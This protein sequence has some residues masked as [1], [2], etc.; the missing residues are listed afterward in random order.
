LPDPL[1]S[2]PYGTVLNDSEGQLIGAKISSDGQWRFP[3]ID[4]VPIYFEEAIT[5]F[6]DKRFRSHIGVDFLSVGRAAIQNLKARQIESGAS[7]KSLECLEKE[8]LEISIRRL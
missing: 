7:C 6:E 2:D 3:M 5:T 4:S 1:F 8:D